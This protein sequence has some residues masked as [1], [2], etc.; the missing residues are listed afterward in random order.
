[1]TGLLVALAVGLPLL[2]GAVLLDRWRRRRMEGAVSGRD[3]LQGHPRYLTQSEI[4]ALPRPGRGASSGEAPAGTQLPFGYVSREFA[5]A[6]D[7]AEY[8]DVWVL[9]VDGDIS[10]TRE[11]MAA[12]ARYRPLVIVARGLEPA[13]LQTLVANRKALDLP[14]LAAVTSEP[15]VAAEHTGAEMLGLADLRAGY[16]P[17]HALGRAAVWVSDRTHTWLIHA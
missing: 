13:M 1:M 16:V 5:T 17:E 3:E 11:F 10:D 12:L 4:D 9:V 14:V 15:A 2:G 7:R 8:R 6:G